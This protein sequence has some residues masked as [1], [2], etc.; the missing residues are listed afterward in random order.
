VLGRWHLVGLALLLAACSEPGAPS[1]SLLSHQPLVSIDDWSGVARDQDEFITEPDAVPSCVG[2]GFFV[3]DSWLEIDT[4]VCSWVTIEGA[5]RFAVEEGQELRLV[6]SHFDLVAL[7]P[8]QGELRLRLGDCD[9]W[10]KSVAIPQPAA[11]DTE[12]FASPCSLEAG[13]AVRFHLHNH[14][15][16]NWQLQSLT[17]LR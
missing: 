13:R 12:A 8:S 6:V 11:V 15:Q 9:A 2:A 1:E 7:E 17:I 5:A 3:E 10:Q 4:T 14:G 16:N